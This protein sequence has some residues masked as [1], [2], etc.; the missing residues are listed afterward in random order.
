MRLTLFI[1][2]I[3]L[4]ILKMANAGHRAPILRE[5]HAGIVWGSVVAHE[6]EAS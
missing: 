5:Q 3:Y 2:I 4:A 6:G 1:G